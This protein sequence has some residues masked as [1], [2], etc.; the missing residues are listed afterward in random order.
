MAQTYTLYF[1]NHTSKEFSW[2]KTD[3]S[4]CKALADALQKNIGWKTTD[5]I[6]IGTEPKHTTDCLEY[7][8][9]LRYRLSKEN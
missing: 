7:L 3:V 8:D 6:R 9:T 1:V 5:D 4:I 2:C